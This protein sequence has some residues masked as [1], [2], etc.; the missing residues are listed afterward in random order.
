MSILEDPFH[1]MQRARLTSPTFGPVELLH[2]TL[3]DTKYKQYRQHIAGGVLNTFT[4]GRFDK[5]RINRM[6]SATRA[7]TRTSLLRLLDS[8]E[9]WLRTGYYGD[10]QLSLKN[11]KADTV[12]RNTLKKHECAL[13]NDA[14]EAAAATISDLFLFGISAVHGY[15]QSAY[16][17]GPGCVNLC[18]DCD[19]MIGPLES[20]LFNHSAQECSNCNRK[21]CYNCSEVAIHS[22]RKAFLP[23]NCRRCC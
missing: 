17:V 12:D 23:K 4:T 2:D 20:M 7:D 18:A 3:T 13:N 9:A 11:P 14:T 15:A 10:I 19:T 6:V 21:R 1:G 22:A 5:N 16:I 8:V